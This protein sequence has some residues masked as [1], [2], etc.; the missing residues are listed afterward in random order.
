MPHL[1]FKLNFHEFKVSHIYFK[2]TKNKHFFQKK[3]LK[4]NQ[5]Q[6]KISR[7]VP[8]TSKNTENGEINVKMT[9]MVK[10]KS[11]S[12]NLN[13]KS[14]KWID[15][16]LANKWPYFAEKL[17][18]I[19]LESDLSEFTETRLDASVDGV[20]WHCLVRDLESGENGE[21]KM[22]AEQMEDG[23]LIECDAREANE[24]FYKYFRIVKTNDFMPV[25][26]VLNVFFSSYFLYF[27]AFE[28]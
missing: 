4:I 5:E 8:K 13:E 16:A 9:K 21:E 23:V 3:Q 26:D 27:F 20:V 19:D 12:E 11:N 7:N 6:S 25:D 18:K 14:E 10:L 2:T 24:S 17:E 15:K 1:I 28:V 22:A